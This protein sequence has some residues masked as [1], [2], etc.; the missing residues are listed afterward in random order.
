MDY[1][2][3]ARLTVIGREELA[4]RVLEGRLSLKEAAID[5][6]AS[7]FPTTLAQGQKTFPL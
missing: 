5:R 3:H 2:H 1:H 7:H 6:L 4:R